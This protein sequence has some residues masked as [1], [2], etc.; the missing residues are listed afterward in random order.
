[1]Q[2]CVGLKI[3]TSG[4][5]PLQYKLRKVG[6]GGTF[7]GSNKIITCIYGLRDSECDLV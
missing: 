5:V 3:I 7:D 2:N 4:C 6:D 1:M